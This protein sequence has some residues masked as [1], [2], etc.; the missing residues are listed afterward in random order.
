[1]REEADIGDVDGGWERGAERAAAEVVHHKLLVGGPEPEPRR[2]LIRR[3]RLHRYTSA[4]S[5][6]QPKQSTRSPPLATV[7]A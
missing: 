4:K 5:R 2:Q 7:L 6:T 3:R 1:M